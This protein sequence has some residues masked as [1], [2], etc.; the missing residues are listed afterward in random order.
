MGL[1]N[2]PNLCCT[3]FLIIMVPTGAVLLYFHLRPTSNFFPT[4]RNFHAEDPF[5]V[6]T[7][8]EAQRW[9]TNGHGLAIT[10]QN[11][12]DSN[13][14]SYFDTAVSDWNSGKPDVLNLTTSVA[15]QPDSNCSAIEGIIK[16]CNGNYGA[17]GWYGINYVAVTNGY[18]VASTA[19][20]ND[21]YLSK[22]S[23][24]RKQYTMCHEIG[25][26]TRTFEESNLLIFWH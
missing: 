18:I 6:T 22:S 14:Y 20:M 25:H 19:L 16:V 23:S 1:S 17:T 11:A 3:V 15:A 9:P 4:L 12:L 13:Y 5:N 21:Y 8:A 2:N 26:G 10:I 7:P 24:D